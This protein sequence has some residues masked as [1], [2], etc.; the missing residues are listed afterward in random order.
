MRLKWQLSKSLGAPKG[1][2]IFLH[3]K[4]CPYSLWSERH[5][6]RLSCFFVLNKTA[7]KWFDPVLL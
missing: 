2:D 4:F 6:I 1:L 5:L 7:Y 3:L